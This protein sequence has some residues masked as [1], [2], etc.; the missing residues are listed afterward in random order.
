MIYCSPNFKGIAFLEHAFFS[1]YP[2][3]LA[4]TRRAVNRDAQNRDHDD[5]AFHLLLTGP[6]RGQNILSFRQ[7]R[8]TT[9]LHDPDEVRDGP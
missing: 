4:C 2:R 3:T 6:R 8:L 7:R 1:F 5:P 9:T